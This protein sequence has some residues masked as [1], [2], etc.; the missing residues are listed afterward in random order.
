LTLPSLTDSL[1]SVLSIK[2]RWPKWKKRIFASRLD[3]VI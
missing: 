1:Q 3:F 2:H